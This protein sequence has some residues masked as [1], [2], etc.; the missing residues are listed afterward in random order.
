MAA[1]VEAGY[2]DLQAQQTQVELYRDRLLPAT[3]QVESLAE[4]SYSAGKTSILSVLAAQQ[5]V[6]EVERSYLDSLSTLQSLLA[7][8]E[9][10]VG[11]PIE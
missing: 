10:T 4:E 8:L 2:F 1:R 9:E 7:A 3:R 6:Q 11:G 5:T